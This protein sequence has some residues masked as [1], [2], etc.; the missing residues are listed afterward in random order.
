VISD[1]KKEL[2]MSNRSGL[3]VLGLI[4]CLAICQ[5]AD[6]Q[7]SADSRPKAAT[8]AATS[9][10]KASTASIKKPLPGPRKVVVR[11]APPVTAATP[12]PIDSE[13]ASASSGYDLKSDVRASADFE[14]SMNGVAQTATAPVPGRGKFQLD[15]NGQ[16][17]ATNISDQVRNGTGLTPRNSEISGFA[18]G[19]RAAYGLTRN[20]YGGVG[21]AWATTKRTDSFSNSTSG[22]AT[23]GTSNSNQTNIQGF[24]E[25]SVILGS[26]YLLNNIRF[27]GEVEGQ[28]G[29]GSRQVTERGTELTADYKDGGTSII[30]RAEVIADVS[31]VRL[32]GEADYQYRMD[33][34]TDVSGSSTPYKL[35]SSG[36]NVLSLF[37]GAELPRFWRAGLM[38]GFQSTDNVRDRTEYSSTYAAPVNGASSDVS[39]QQLNMVLVQAYL[40]FAVM[41]HALIVPKVAY[42]TSIDRQANGLQVNKYDTW[43]FGLSTKLQF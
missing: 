43:S 16:G 23:P 32:F 24:K 6:A 42:S 33:R 26:Q 30:P 41:E 28:I 3:V 22:L 7:P 15:L 18:T 20:F 34:Q 25:P 31:I 10:V 19:V 40:G 1:I 2:H 4:S 39:T 27:I 37:A 11:Q 5:F 8:R 36:G 9:A 12:N 21:F 38:T 17:I 13:M 14:D 35:K 29:I